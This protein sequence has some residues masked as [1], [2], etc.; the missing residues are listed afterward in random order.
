M[1]EYIMGAVL[2]LIV[3]CFFA[4]AMYNTSAQE[5][6]SDEKIIEDVRIELYYYLKTNTSRISS[7]YI[8]L[9]KKLDSLETRYLI[10]YGKPYEGVKRD[11]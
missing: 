9:C 3:I 4:F 6:K 11:E 2:G 5:R 8:N 10:N 1:S 7:D